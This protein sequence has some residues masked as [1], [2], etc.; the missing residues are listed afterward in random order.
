MGRL[1]AAILLVVSDEA[2]SRMQSVH[3]V[4][5]FDR[6]GWFTARGSASRKSF[7]GTR[8]SKRTWASDLSPALLSLLTQHPE[9]CRTVA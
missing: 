9:D 7:R 4:Y 5:L 1:A 8:R 3:A 2:W 6:S